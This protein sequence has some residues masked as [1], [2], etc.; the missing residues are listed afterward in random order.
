M[1]LLSTIMEL[2]QKQFRDLPEDLVREIVEI[3]T[4]YAEDRTEALKRVDQALERYLNH[5]PEI[6]SC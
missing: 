2:R 4:R 3:E 5:L 1:D 6:A